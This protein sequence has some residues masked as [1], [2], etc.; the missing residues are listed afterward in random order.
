MNT[1]EAN[2]D[3]YNTANL[4]NYAEAL[5]DYLFIIHGSSDSTVVL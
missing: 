5:D 1:P 3:A 2:P 4:L